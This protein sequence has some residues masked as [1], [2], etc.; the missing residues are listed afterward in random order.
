[1]P[2]LPPRPDITRLHTTPMGAGRIRRN[3]SLCPNT[4]A[5]DF[6]RRIVSAAPDCNII[7]RGKNFYVHTRNIVITIN[8]H[9]N[10]IITAHKTV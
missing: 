5:V 4:D 1:M 10:T 9:S 6:V 2:N 3:L 7:S 8:A